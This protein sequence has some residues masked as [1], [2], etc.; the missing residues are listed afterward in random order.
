MPLTTDLAVRVGNLR[1]TVDGA[2]DIPKFFDTEPTVA[3]RWLSNQFGDNLREVHDAL[4]KYRTQLEENQRADVGSWDYGAEKNTVR[5]I[6]SVLTR[7]GSLQSVDGWT[8]DGP[9]IEEL[10][11]ELRVLHRLSTELPRHLQT[12]M[13]DLA[14][15]VRCATGRGSPCPGSPARWQR[16]CSVCLVDFFTLGFFSR[17]DYYYKVR[18]A[19]R[20]GTLV[21]GFTWRPRTKWPNLPT[22]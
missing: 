2:S 6:E 13:S 7:I 12:R 8:R 9:M 4:D 15:D 20:P 17:Y 3:C 1:A 19:S 10:K 18:V 5:E 22:R 16:C 14:V 11:S 21:I